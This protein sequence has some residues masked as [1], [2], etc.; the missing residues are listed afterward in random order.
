MEASGLV[1]GYSFWTFSDIFEENYSSRLVE[2]LETAS[3][4]VREPMPLA[5]QD[6]TIAVGLDLPPHG[7]A[8]ITLELGDHP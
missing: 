5:Y 7:V 4:L 8:A 2:E 3:R 6:A 1:D